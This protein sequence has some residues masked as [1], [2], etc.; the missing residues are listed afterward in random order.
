[1][2]SLLFS[3][4]LLVVS[5]GFVRAQ[6]PA[7]AQALQPFVDAH[8]LAGAVT[9][10][11]TGE[12]IKSV[13][14]V[15]Y[16]DLETQEP[17]R[18]GDLFWIASMTKPMTASCL[19]M[20]VDEGKIALDDPVE[21]YLP[22]FQGQM[23]ARERSKARVVLER[24]RHPVT[25]REVLSHTAGLVDRSPLETTGDALPLKIKTITYGL[26][27]LQFQP[28]T[29]FKYC[30]PGINTAGRLVEVVSG[31]PYERFMQERLLDPLGMDETTFWPTEK[32]LEHLAH[33]YRPKEGGEGLEEVRIVRLSYPLTSRDRQPYAGGGLFSTAEDLSRFGR[34]ILNGGEFEGR[35]LLSE[36]AVRAMTSTQTG[37]LMNNGKDE[38]GYG[39]GF[40]TTRDYPG[41]DG[42]VIP[43]AVEHGGSY[44]TYLQIDP[45]S[46]LVMVLLVQQA[47]FAEGVQGKI[48]E[49]FR[50]A[51]RGTFGAGVK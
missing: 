17:M 42:P 44:S 28:G 9:L 37:E 12:G 3:L 4:A 50:E 1:M 20:L 16:A 13:Q 40:F 38:H 30:N 24:A 15:G 43:G 33:A 11:A 48:R 2:R 10:V 34:M 51:A 47:R 6:E 49:R 23:V 5:N 29:R 45:E 25:V 7:I 21:T 22:E 14:A 39:L 26:L 32:D 18:T 46:G 35:R 36:K 27:P 8:E 31:M 19:M 41:E